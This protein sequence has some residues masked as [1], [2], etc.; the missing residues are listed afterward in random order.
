MRKS[1]TRENSVDSCL[2]SAARRSAMV[3][4]PARSSTAPRRGLQAA[5][6]GAAH[7]HLC[8]RFAPAAGHLF[9]SPLCRLLVL[10]RP[11]AS[12]LL[13]VAQAR[14]P[15]AADVYLRLLRH[16]AFERRDACAGSGV[17]LRRRRL[18]LRAGGVSSAW[19]APRSAARVPFL[20]GVGVELH[21]EPGGLGGDHS[22]CP[23]TSASSF[24][25]ARGPVRL[26]CGPL[27]FR[28]AR[29]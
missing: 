21:A 25:A 29:R 18:A 12:L 20:G 8:A 2:T 13:R 24:L 7:F 19:A 22:S 26:S 10:T 23:R 17:E 15:A 1:A 27:P 28:C 6:R 5:A 9:N 14:S 3:D 11:R 4:A 16:L